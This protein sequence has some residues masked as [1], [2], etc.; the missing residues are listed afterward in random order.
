[1]D[2]ES[3]VKFLPA[4]ELPHVQLNLPHEMLQLRGGFLDEERRSKFITFWNDKP[5][6]TPKF[7]KSQW[8]INYGFRIPALLTK[9][10][11][12]FFAKM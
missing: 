5:L 3:R 7:I 9:Q 10:V 6:I 1:M 11:V 12:K 2:E 4:K 8:F